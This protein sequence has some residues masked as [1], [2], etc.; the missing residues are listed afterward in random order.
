MAA[1]NR[2]VILLKESLVSPPAKGS[3]RRRRALA[4]IKTAGNMAAFHLRAIS[5]KW[6][7]IMI[8]KSAPA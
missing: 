5:M 7:I 8:I 2:L 6:S 4:V 1:N 3:K